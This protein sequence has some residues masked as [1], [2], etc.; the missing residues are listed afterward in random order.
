MCGQN[1]EFLFHIKAVSRTVHL[2]FLVFSLTV[3]EQWSGGSQ[4]AVRVRT[5]VL[6]FDGKHTLLMP[7]EL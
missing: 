2:S 5:C 3:C 4:N 1:A 6:R 7:V